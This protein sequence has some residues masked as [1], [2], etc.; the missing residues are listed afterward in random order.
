MLVFPGRN[1]KNYSFPVPGR[2]QTAAACFAATRVS[3]LHHIGTARV[4][5][6][7]ELFCVTFF[8]F[9]DC[10]V[11]CRRHTPASITQ[12]T[13]YRVSKKKRNIARQNSMQKVAFLLTHAVQVEEVGTQPMATTA[14]SWSKQ[15][16]AMWFKNVYKLD[17]I[18]CFRNFLSRQ[19]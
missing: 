13:Y 15:K 1:T 2:N 4:W 18:A 3:R 11:A 10:C 5:H 9:H 8:H 14:I 16:I 12:S 6:Y 7:F 19:K 17:R